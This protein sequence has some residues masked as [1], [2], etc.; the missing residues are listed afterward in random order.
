ML[1]DNPAEIPLPLWRELAHALE[2]VIHSS[3]S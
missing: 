1:T 2:D 3:S